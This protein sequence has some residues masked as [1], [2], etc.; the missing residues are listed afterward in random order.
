M[1]TLTNPRVTQSGRDFKVRIS[2]GLY[3]VEHDDR[4]GLWWAFDQ[5]DLRLD[6]GRDPLSCSSDACSGWERPE[7]LIAVLLAFDGQEVP[8]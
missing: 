3:L 7:D 4:D 6:R 2:H 1:S 5:D 8:A